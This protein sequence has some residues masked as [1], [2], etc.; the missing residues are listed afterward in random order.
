MI[1]E[2]CKK[3][4]AAGIP[5]G[6]GG[7]AK[8]GDGMLPAEKIIMEHYRLGS[9]RA[10]LSRSFCDTSKITDIEEIERIF[11]ENM[12]SLRE[13]EV[14]MADMSQEKF[15]RNKVEVEKAVDEIAERIYQARS[16]GL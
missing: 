13:Y 5:Y 2:L 11:R 15:V 8:L 7:I 6:F 4:K 12:E 9:T 14:S 16:A 1:E 10:I 3:F